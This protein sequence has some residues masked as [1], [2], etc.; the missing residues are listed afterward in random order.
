MTEKSKNEFVLNAREVD[1]FFI[2]IHKRYGY[3]FLNYSRAS[4]NRRLTRFMFNNQ[5]AAVKDLKE[6]LLSD[7]ELFEFFVEELMVNVTEMFRDPS[8]FKTL[9]EKVVPILSTYPHIRI[10]DAG[11]ST[12]EELLSLAIILHEEK[13]L[14]KTRIYATDINQRSLI[15]AKKGAVPL[16]DINLYSNNYQNS[17]GK[18]K[19]SDYYHENQKI[20]IFNPA[21]LSNVVF[22]PHNLATDTSFNEFHLILCRNVFIYF[23]KQLQE[24]VLHLFIESLSPLGFLSLGKKETISLSVHAEAFSVIDNEEK[25]FRKIKL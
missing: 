5:F 18:K 3:D 15:T 14:K 22:Y 13:L 19:L 23:N 20:A 12:G 9:R 11:C 6:S 7:P 4:V 16:S 24:R 17:G 2:E 25:I 8:F 1:R 21:L 10:W